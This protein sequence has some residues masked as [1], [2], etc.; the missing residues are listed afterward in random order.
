MNDRRVSSAS[1]EDVVNR[2]AYLLFY[3]RRNPSPTVRAS[4][5]SPRVCVPEPR[6]SVSKTQANESKPAAEISPNLRLANNET[7]KP[8]EIF[9]TDKLTNIQSNYDLNSL[10]DRQ[11][12]DIDHANEDQFD[13]LLLPRDTMSR[14]SK[15]GE[16]ID[17][18]SQS[19]V[20][21]TKSMPICNG[22]SQSGADVN[23]IC[24]SSVLNGWKDMSIDSD[25]GYTD[26]DEMD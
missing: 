22:F 5:L 1:E 11:T 24:E 8:S 23:G 10:S 19:T 4:P 18:A 21:I 9:E 25:L 2:S 3:K 6:A 16:V 26:M 13:E 15:S 7:P 20:E 14:T 17:N 12:T